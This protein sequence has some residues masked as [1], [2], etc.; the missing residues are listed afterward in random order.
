MLRIVDRETV[1]AYWL[2]L[3]MLEMKICMHEKYRII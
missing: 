2:T 1:A 3:S